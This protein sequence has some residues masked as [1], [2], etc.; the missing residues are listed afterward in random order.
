MS[1]IFGIITYPQ[2]RKVAATDLQAMAHALVYEPHYRE[3]DPTLHLGH[4]GM[5]VVPFA[6]RLAGTAE[7]VVHGQSVALVFFGSLYNVRHLGVQGRVETD[8][9]D[10]LLQLYVAEG[11]SFV[12]RLRGDFVIAVWDGRDLALH[13]F[14]DRFRVHPIFYAYNRSQF[15]FASRMKALL[16]TSFLEEPTVN[17]EAVVDTLASSF[18]PTPKTIFTQVQKLP[19]GAVLTYRR[20]NVSIDAYWDINFL[21]PESTDDL[22]LVRTLKQRFINSL[23]VRLEQDSTPECIGT[24]LSGGIDSSTVTGTLSQLI[25]QPVKSFSIGFDEQRFNEMS[26]A[27]LA[28]RAFNVE[29]YEYFVTPQDVFTATP[30]LLETFDEPFANASAIPTYFCAKLAR[31]HGVDRVYAGDGGDELFAGNE[32]YAALR[33]FEYYDRLPL[34]LRNA[35]I[36]PLINVLADSLQLSLLIKGKKYIRRASIP[37]PDRLSSY[38]FFRE[39]ALSHWLTSE[40]LE[41]VGSSYDPYLSTNIYY[42]QAPARSDLDRQMYID[43]KLAIADNDLFKVTRMTESVGLTVRYP[44][45]DHRL[46]EFAASIPAE[47]K[48]PASDLRVFFKKAYVDL[49]PREIVHKKKHGF[50]LPIPVWLRTY[51]PLNEM[52]LDLVLSPRSLQRGYFRRQAIEELVE[53]HRTETSTSFHG[54]ILWNLMILEMWHRRYNDTAQQVESYKRK[55]AG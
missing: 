30:L 37:Y 38:S 5:G 47:R 24:F 3:V 39:V 35:V 21:H 7:S 54:T 27:R 6:G 43:L 16:V 20:G 49:L 10:A 17:A 34:W 46:A 40:F 28:A 42:F 48:M 45:L 12:E 41:T 13:L 23:M 22:T 29:H 8:I 33:V 51:K 44:F 36:S 4:V 26:Y 25:D 2:D 32:R 18:V 53:Q 55:V 1:G 52:M 14:T 50:G 11:T 15:I 31:E 19:P 9:L